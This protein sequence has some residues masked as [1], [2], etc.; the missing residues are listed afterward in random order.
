MKRSILAV[1]V[2]SFA[3][4]GCNTA[5]NYFEDD[6]AD[7]PQAQPGGFNLFHTMMKHTGVAPKDQKRLAYKPRAPLAMPSSTELPAPMHGKASEAET[8]VNFPQD[9]EDSEADRKARLA[10]LLGSN[11]DPNALRDDQNSP[12][13]RQTVARLP[14][15]AL[16]GNRKPVD[17]SEV[18]RD[19]N[20][21]R[22]MKEMRKKLNFRKPAQAVLTE[23][24]E[25]TPR[26]YLIQPPE[27]YRTP[28]ETAALPEQGD[29][30]NSDWIKKQLYRNAKSSPHGYVSK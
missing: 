28:A 4:S 25:A 5:Y 26:K 18:F 19:K 15:E 27:E 7:A 13:S 21:V 1:V 8:A 9:H 20:P 12:I 30:E 22:S 16:A 3:L 6:V 10:T 29:I 11:E 23:T 24:G 17:N 2:I 14:P